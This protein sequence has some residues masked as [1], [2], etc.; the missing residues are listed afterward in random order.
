MYREQKKRKLNRRGRIVVGAG[1]AVLALLVLLGVS[2]LSRGKVEITLN[3]DP[4]LRI[5]Y[6]Q[7]HYSEL[8]AK[9]VY[10]GFLFTSRVKL[11]VEISG[12]PGTYAVPGEYTVTYKA[13][14]RGN[15]ASVT[16]KV[17]IQDMTPPVIWLLEEEDHF[18]EAG[19]AYQEEG[20]HAFD[21]VDGDLTDR[22]ESRDGGDGYIYY[23]V[24]DSAGNT[25]ETRREVKYKDTTSPVISL[26]GGEYMVLTV[27]DS[28][29]DPG[30]TALDNAD[31]DI[32]ARISGS[33]SVDSSA[34]GIYT[35]TYAVRDKAG[36][37]AQ[38][39]RTVT[40]RASAS[41]ENPQIPAGSTGVIYLTFD[42]GP[43][44]YTEDLLDLLNR[45]GIKVTFFVTNQR[46]D[47]RYVI[48]RVAAEGHS[49]GIHSATHSTQIYASEEAFFEDFKKCQD[50]IYEQ[51]GEYTTLFRFPGGS[52]NT[53]SNFNP[54]I[55]SRLT[56]TMT[57]MGYYYF[58]W[59]VT[60]GDAGET[61]DTDEVYWNVR[62]GC[63]S[64]VSVVLQHDIK[65]FSVAAV[66]RI[67]I[68]GLNN[69]YQFLPLEESSYGAHHRINN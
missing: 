6:G 32:S 47:Y 19:E 63:T 62:S 60:S 53:V 64:N 3:G 34:M 40:V 52:S 8:G 46:P 56:Q 41:A 26:I 38:A 9:A 23:S 30:A 18:T 14:Y 13:S 10:K 42:D 17:I 28:F 43:G 16:R 39:V 68:W 7:Q 11:D 25:A 12:Q 31:G 24:T 48:A 67:I 55:M 54:G 66:E 44:P 50:M 20:Y 69:G 37:G 5:S 36:N 59:N 35:L 49:I 15:A 51:T 33:G 65:G 27:G 61:T 57:E 45:Y 29:S 21:K 58:D 2:F 1:C 4:E 22:V